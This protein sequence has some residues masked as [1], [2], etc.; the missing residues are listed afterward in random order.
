[1]RKY[2]TQQEHFWAS[3][4]GN[5]YIKRN[6]GEALL[7]SN[8]RFFVHALNQC[9]ELK[10]C[11][12]F[13]ANIGTNLMALRLLYPKMGLRAIEINQ[14]AAN[15]LRDLLGAEY[16]FEGSML[17]YQ[18]SDPADLVLVK[19]VLIHQNPEILASVYKKIYDSSSSYILLA[20]YYSP[21]PVELPY[22]GHLGYL[23]KR[24]FAGEMLDMF[25]D[26]MLLDSGFS[27]HRH[28]S[29]PQDDVTWF[30]LKK[31]P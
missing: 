24:D 10:T 4:F 29:F 2:A 21:K 15:A 9:S 28:P 13:G 30:L 25:P 11:I 8:L 3:E 26:L 5:D 31:K 23:F 22:R 27:Y 20:E 16:V 14:T 18:A 7:A 12:E 1:M 6:Q 17:D 19:G